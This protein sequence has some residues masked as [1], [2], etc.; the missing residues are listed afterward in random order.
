MH[1]KYI[2][3]TII[4]LL[5]A[6]SG[7]SSDNST[8]EHDVKIS[9]GYGQSIVHFNNSSQLNFVLEYFIS[10]NLSLDYWFASNFSSDNTFIHTP[11]GLV[12]GLTLLS[13]TW[14]TDYSTYDYLIL[15]LIILPEGIHY[16]MPMNEYVNLVSYLNPLGYDYLVDDYSLSSTIGVKLEIVP[17]ENIS[18]NPFAGLKIFYSHPS[19][20]FGFD[21]GFLLG[22]RF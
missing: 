13:E 18:I 11:L 22:I 20:T 14:K 10:K 3:F 6:E 9:F 19:A 21:F 15:L 7:I 1:L 5:S 12:A 17:L 2:L 16:Y 4:F 8:K